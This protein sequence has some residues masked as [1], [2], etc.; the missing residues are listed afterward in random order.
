MA[1]GVRSPSSP[2]F[3]GTGTGNDGQ[4]LPDVGT[5]AYEQAA[6]RRGAANATVL[7]LILGI[8]GMTQEYRHRTATPTF[9][10]TPRRGRVV[11]AKLLAYAPGRRPH[12]SCW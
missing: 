1:G 11:A 6:F 10:V 4:A 5:S 3:A 8:I 9:L 12:R 2:S 7:L